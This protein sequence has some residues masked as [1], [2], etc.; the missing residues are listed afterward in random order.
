M[1]I[2]I[3]DHLINIPGDEFYDQLIAFL[4]ILLGGI[5]NWGRID[6]LLHNSDKGP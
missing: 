2:S 4:V 3:I 1:G 6:L 5:K